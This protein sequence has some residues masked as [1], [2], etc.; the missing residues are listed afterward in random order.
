MNTAIINLSFSTL[1][2]YVVSFVLVMWTVIDAARRPPSDLPSRQKAVWIIGSVIGWLLFGVVG[3]FV[4]IVYLVV[5][6][7]RMNANRW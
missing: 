2:L 5:P 1:L 7:R 4:A 6:R 3:A